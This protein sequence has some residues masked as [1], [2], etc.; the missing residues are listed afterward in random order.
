MAA[1]L[2]F[3][4]VWDCVV[5]VAKFGKPT[6]VVKQAFPVYRGM[7]DF[8][9]SLLREGACNVCQLCKECLRLECLSVACVSFMW[10]CSGG[11]AVAAALVLGAA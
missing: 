11:W 9:P 1:T 4:V 2:A 3:W 7:D 6:I 5:Q 10:V 8:L